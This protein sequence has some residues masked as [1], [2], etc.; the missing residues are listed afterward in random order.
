MQPI[1]TFERINTRP[2]IQMIGISPNDLS[3]NIPSAHEN[4]RP[5]TDAT[6]P[7][8]IKSAFQYSMISSYFA[9]TRIWI[10]S[11]CCSSKFI[12][13]SYKK[14]KNYRLVKMWPIEYYSIVKLIKFSEFRWPASPDFFRVK[15]HSIKVILLQCRAIGLNIICFCYCPLANFD[16]II[17]HEIHICIFR[18]RLSLNLFWDLA[19]LFQP[20]W[21]DFES[22][23]SRK[24]FTFEKCQDRR[25][26]FPPTTHINC[27]PKQMPKTGCL[28]NKWADQDLFQRYS[29][30]T[31]PPTT[32]KITPNRHFWFRH[33]YR[34]QL[35][36]PNTFE[37]KHYWTYISSIVF[38]NHHFIL[39]TLRF[40]WIY[41]ILLVAGIGKNSRF[42]CPG[43]VHFHCIR[44][45]N[46][47]ISRL[48][49]TGSA[50]LR[51][52]TPDPRYPGLHKFRIVTIVIVNNTYFFV[53]YDIG[54]P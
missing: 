42:E 25:Y 49:K 39:F 5:L 22:I 26:Y 33:D 8:G 46:N 54:H 9:A 18:R 48:N 2:Q 11:V 19:I 30:Q 32:I 13:F 50:P 16:I 52:I 47:N 53:G 20:I 3:L 14:I 35:H 40:Y 15:L 28:R 4:E 41:T 37:R 51:Q 29:L 43:F 6:V 21:G 24:S 12:F 45:N 23:G 36:G 27:I 44:H 10:G 7:T 17:M 1:R 38:Y 34:L 31:K